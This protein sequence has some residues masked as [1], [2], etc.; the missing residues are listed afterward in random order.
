[1]SSTRLTRAIVHSQNRMRRC[2]LSQV[3][4]STLHCKCAIIMCSLRV[5]IST[6]SWDAVICS[7]EKLRSSLIILLIQSGRS[8][9]GSAVVS[10][11]STRN[12]LFQS[13][14]SSLRLQMSTRSPR[15]SLDSKCNALIVR[16]C[17]CI[18][19]WRNWLKFHKPTTANAM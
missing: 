8:M 1:M 3:V 5:V 9:P 2:T 7:P 17:K 16:T 4:A 13:I 14:L 18:L 12:R 11:K 10:H 19:R 6:G 15:M